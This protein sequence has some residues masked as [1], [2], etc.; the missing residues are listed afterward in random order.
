MDFTPRTDINLNQVEYRDQNQGKQFADRA[1]KRKQKFELKQE[2]KEKVI[3]E[4]KKSE[5]L[6]KSS[7]SARKRHRA[8]IDW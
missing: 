7:L 3:L 5:K 6:K 2:N 8:E 4:T 1:E